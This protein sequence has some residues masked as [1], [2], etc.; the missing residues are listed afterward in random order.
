MRRGRRGRGVGGRKLVG[1]WVSRVA[2]WWGDGV[3]GGGMGLGTENGG[4]GMGD[5]GWGMGTG[6]G[7]GRW[8][9]YIGIGGEGTRGG[10]FV[11][12]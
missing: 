6:K 4:W 3:K 8:G 12:V 7:E 5:G 2:G 10:A 1:G 11:N 9:I